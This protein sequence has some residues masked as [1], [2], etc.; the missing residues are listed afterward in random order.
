MPEGG[1]PAISRRRSRAQRELGAGPVGR[2]A[3]AARLRARSAQPARLAVSRRGDGIAAGGGPSGALP[4]I[5]RAPAQHDP[6]FHRP[7]RGP[8]AVSPEA[9]RLARRRFTSRLAPSSRRAPP[10]LARLD[11]QRLPQGL[12]G[13]ARLV[14]R[15]LLRRPLGDEAAAAVAALRSEEHTSELQS[16]TN[17]VCRLL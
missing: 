1:R 14:R 13:V 2:R 4:V 7:P 8:G 6:G 3:A 15:D 16:L 5:A 10:R 17:L 12:A 11:A 9:P